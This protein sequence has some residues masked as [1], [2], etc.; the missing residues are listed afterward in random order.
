[1][2]LLKLHTTCK[3]YSSPRY[4][5]KGKHGD[6]KISQ[7]SISTHVGHEYWYWN[8]RCTSDSFLQTI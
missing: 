8:K 1:M 5:H 7:N 3:L 4:S 6:H 2:P